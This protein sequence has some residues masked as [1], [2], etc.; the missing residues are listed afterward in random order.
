M[1]FWRH[2]Q[3]PAPTQAA[4]V[5]YTVRPRMDPDFKVWVTNPAEV[6]GY[7]R[8]DLEAQV[9][10]VVDYLVKNFPD[11]VSQGETLLTLSVPDLEADIAVKRAQLA[12]RKRELEVYEN[13]EVVAARAV[14]TAGDMLKEARQYEMAAKAEW[15]YRETRAGRFERLAGQEQAATQDIADETRSEAVKA[16][17]AYYAASAS[18]DRAQAELA[19][20]KAKSEESRADTKLRQSEME[21]AGTELEKAKALRDFAVIRAPWDG[22]IT[23]PR[24]VD[25][26]SFVSNASSGHSDPLLTLERTDILTVS[27]NFPDAYAPYIQGPNG[28]EAGTEFELSIPELPG[29]TVHGSVTRVDRTLE[30]PTNDRTMRVEVDLF[31][32]SD[33]DYQLLR[34]W[35]ATPNDVMRLSSHLAGLIGSPLGQ[36]PLLAASGLCPGRFR[37]VLKGGALPIQPTV[38][39]KQGK[40]VGESAR[41][42]LLKPGMFGDMRLALRRFPDAYLL[43]S[44]AVFSRGGERYVYVVKDGTAVLTPVDVPVEQ[45][46]D[47]QRLGGDPKAGRRVVE[48]L[49]LLKGP[50]GGTTSLGADDEVVAADQGELLERRQAVK[51]WHVKW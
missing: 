41:L 32:G 45:E 25:P 46:A 30:T 24:R 17:A 1:L 48:A 39:D 35:R 21:R 11:P 37:E 23:G 42:N 3:A 38:T 44:T 50:N 40:T 36:G 5:F 2:A 7:Y 10:G 20:A 43:P 16:K 4:T 29:V 49:V 27:A 19:E 28:S 14:D 31:M 34:D 6:H 12:D 15:D 33:E 22:F 26:G 13:R 8:I 18:V 47:E 51:T 9:P